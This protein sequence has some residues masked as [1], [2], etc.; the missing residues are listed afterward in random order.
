VRI[1][2]AIQEL[3]AGGA[4]RVVVS[5][6]NGVRRA[7]HDVAVAAAAGPLSAEIDG[8]HYPLPLIG[9]RPWRL[10]QAALALDRAIRDWEPTIVHC[11]NPGVAATAALATMRGRRVPTVVTVQGVPEEDYER[12]ARVLKGAGLQVV[13][14]GPGVTAALELQ[15]VHVAE[16][17]VNGVSAPPPPASRAALATE[18]GFDPSRPLLVTV[19][20]LVEQKGQEL[21]IRALALIPEAFLVIAGEGPLRGHLTAVAREAGVLDRVALPGVRSDARRLLGAAD[22]VVLPSRWEGLPLVALEALSGGTPV[23]ATAVRGVSELLTDGV[24]AVLVPAGDTEALSA[25]VRSLLEDPAR[26]ESLARAGRELARLYS[27]D[28]MTTRYL[29]LYERLTG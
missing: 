10:P 25:A 28:A 16:T 1:L 17:I 5:L 11:H 8:P 14:C 23:V 18:L 22:V 6:A 20:R 26:A 21:A 13:S 7:G 27:E 9:R 19:G 29:E 12:S 24:D 15:G 2:Q 3:Q 4:E